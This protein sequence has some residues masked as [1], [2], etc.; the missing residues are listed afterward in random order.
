MAE[1]RI[2][3]PSCRKQVVP[4]LW[5]VRKRLSYLLTQHLCPFCGAVMYETGGAPRWGCIIAILIALLLLCLPA[6]LVLISTALR[7][8]PSP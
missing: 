6:I 5:H 4:R 2:E 7:K 8:A 3:C 1:E